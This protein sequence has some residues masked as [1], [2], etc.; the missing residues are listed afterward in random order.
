MNDN[1]ISPNG[2]STMKLRQPGVQICRSPCYI[3]RAVRGAAPFSG[4]EGLTVATLAGGADE[5]ED[6]DADCR[7]LGQT[8]LK[9]FER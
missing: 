3:A 2:H 7:E 8:E 9:T 4:P 5:E 1:G 6:N